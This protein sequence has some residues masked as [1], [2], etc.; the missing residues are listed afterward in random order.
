VQCPALEIFY[1]AKSSNSKSTPEVA[2]QRTINVY[3]K[4]CG[5]LVYSS[6]ATN[7]YQKKIVT[8]KKKKIK[9]LLPGVAVLVGDR[10]M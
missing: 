5:R 2:L 9:E 1:P 10:E 4:Q 8:R 6:R 3:Q 7:V